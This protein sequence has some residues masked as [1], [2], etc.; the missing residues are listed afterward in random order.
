[1]FLVV[2]STVDEFDSTLMEYAQNLWEEGD[3]VC[4]LNYT[5]SACH[6]FV[7]SLKNR[8]NGSWRLK[9]TWCKVEPSRKASPFNLLMCQAMAGYFCRCGYQRAALVIM[10]SFACILR[11]AEFMNLLVSDIVS[12]DET[13]FLTLRDRKVGQRL[14][15]V[16][17]TSC[18][19]KWLCPRLRKSL[20]GR[21][22]GER[23]V[24]MSAHTFRRIFAA[25]RQAMG[26]PSTYTPY[27]IRRGGA[28]ALFKASGSYNVVSNQG[29]WASERT[30]RGYLDSA[31]VELASDRE[32]QCW[33]K[34]HR[35]LAK[36]LHQLAR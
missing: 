29:R 33:H 22:N 25:G 8:L 35:A 3:G 13:I 16:Q 4:T 31:L 6:H 23:V 27:S 36:F 5:L 17:T 2:P 26:L 11:T 14:G 12:T 20:R 32:L 34:C 9:K 21:S 15:V 10:L 19:D 24:D 18:T 28:T 7:P 1:M 30:M